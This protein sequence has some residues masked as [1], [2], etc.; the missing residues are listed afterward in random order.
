MASGIPSQALSRI[1]HAFEQ[2]SNDP[3]LAR[4]GTGLGLALVRGLV[5]EHGGT[6]QIDSREN[7]GTTVSVELPLTPVQRLVAA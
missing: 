7:V 1:G 6:M 4:K 2:A 3:L 5:R